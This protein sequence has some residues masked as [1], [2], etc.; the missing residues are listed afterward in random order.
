[1]I[2][3]QKRNILSNI[4]AQDAPPVFMLGGMYLAHFPYAEISRIQER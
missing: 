4:N 3:D 1:M 2:A